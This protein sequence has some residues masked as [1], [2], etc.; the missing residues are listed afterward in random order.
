MFSLSTPRP[1]GRLPDDSHRANR[2][3]EAAIIHFYHSSGFVISG[4]GG[5]KTA[6]RRSGR[7]LTQS[8]RTCAA[9]ELFSPADGSPGL[10]FCENETNS[11]DSLTSQ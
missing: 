5:R 2:G 8:L 11:D 10:L 1:A 7:R 6:S 3:P 9:W 4:P